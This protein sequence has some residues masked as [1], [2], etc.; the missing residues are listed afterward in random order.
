MNDWESAKVIAKLDKINQM[1]MKGH[2]SVQQALSNIYEAPWE[3]QLTLKSVT[4]GIK[5][6]DEGTGGFQCGEC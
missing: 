5:K 3:D 1:K 2:T 4:T 6:L